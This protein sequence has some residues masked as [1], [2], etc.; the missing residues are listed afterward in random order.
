[1][2]FLIVSFVN[3]VF[4]GGDNPV[5][6][7]RQI[8]GVYFWREKVEE[9][10][11]NFFCTSTQQSLLLPIVQNLLQDESSE[12]RLNVIGEL[13]KVS[14]GIGFRELSKQI[15]PAVTNLATDSKWRVRE[16]VVN[17]IPSLAKLMGPEAFEQDLSKIVVGWLTDQVCEIRTQV[18]EVLC[19][20]WGVFGEQ[21]G[22]TALI[23]KVG[24]LVN[25]ENYMHRVALLYFLG[26]AAKSKHCSA[27]VINTDF[28]PFFQTMAR[29]KVPNVR[30]NVAKAIEVC[31]CLVPERLSSF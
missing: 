25:K 1:M 5:E 3:E 6:T 30:F 8:F 26:T 11:Y 19:E 29:D 9:K 20:L 14:D 21:W 18:A 4:F 24:V 17:V 23:K 22:R 16:G 7:V 10:V 28:L 31:P 12:V 2:R 27:F 15:L 13:G